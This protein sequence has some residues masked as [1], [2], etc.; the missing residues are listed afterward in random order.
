MDLNLVDTCTDNNRDTG[1]LSRSVEE[2]WSQK[3]EPCFPTVGH[4]GFRLS[5]KFLIC[6]TTFYGPVPWHVSYS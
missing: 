6:P 2:V 3:S 4:Y 1:T 5:I